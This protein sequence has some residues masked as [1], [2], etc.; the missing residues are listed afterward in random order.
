MGTFR[1]TV[2][3]SRGTVARAADIGSKEGVAEKE[4]HTFSWGNVIFEKRMFTFVS[5]KVAEKENHTYSG[6]D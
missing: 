3:N 1:S 5:D 4:N 6:A 2:A